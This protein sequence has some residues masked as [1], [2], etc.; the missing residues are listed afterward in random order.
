MPIGVCANIAQTSIPCLC[1]FSFGY[2]PLIIAVFYNQI[3]ELN[4]L[5]STRFYTENYHFIYLSH[6]YTHMIVGNI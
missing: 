3:N 6:L 5:Y 4:D 2:S 1:N